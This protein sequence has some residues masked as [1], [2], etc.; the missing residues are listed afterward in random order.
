[1]ASA[2]GAQLH[3]LRDADLIDL[4]AAAAHAQRVEGLDEQWR[5]ELTYW[6]AGTRDEGLGIPDAAIPEQA[7]Q[8]T[9]PGRDFGRDGSL[10]VGTGHDRAARY[11][12]L[13]SDEDS[14]TAWLR[15]GEA[16]SAV[17]LTAT[18]HGL[19][20]LPL[21]AA[22]EVPGTRQ[23]LRQMLADVGEPLLVLRIGVPAPRPDEPHTPRLPADQQI[24]LSES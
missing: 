14:P 17:W 21:S 7:P 16:L 2:E 8:T 18:A 4:A 23:T 19:S 13:F 3:I 9:V 12:I 11:A 20:V 1:M 5:G 6:V 22:V 24:E 10:A 15:G